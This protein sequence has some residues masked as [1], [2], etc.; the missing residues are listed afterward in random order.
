MP[1]GI[2]ENILGLKIPINNLFGMQILQG[3]QYFGGIE[4]GRIL[5]E[6]LISPQEEEELTL[7]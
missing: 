3:Q 7:D 5:V 1:L 6:L 2:Q 4:P